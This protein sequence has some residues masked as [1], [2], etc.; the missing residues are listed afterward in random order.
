MTNVVTIK[1]LEREY[2]VGCP[3]ERT[4]SLQAAAKV[5]DAQMREIQGG[6]K[7]VSLDRVAVLAALN[8]AHEL[9]QTRHTTA[10]DL[11]E[12]KRRIR[13][14]GERMDGELASQ[15]RLF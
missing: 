14:M 7:T 6:N 13:S 3:P 5:L 15:E 8:I 11:P 1:V 12:L 9:I 10:V 4:D 2:T